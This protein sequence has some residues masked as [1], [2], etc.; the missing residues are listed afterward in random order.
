MGL[1]GRLFTY[2]GA[3]VSHLTTGYD[4]GEVG[5]LAVLTILT[6]LSWALRPA[7]RRLR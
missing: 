7:S 1:R 6:V 3:I 4:R 5:L 2:T